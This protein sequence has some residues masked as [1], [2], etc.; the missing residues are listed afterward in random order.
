MG[1]EPDVDYDKDEPFVFAKSPRAS[2]IASGEKVMIPPG[3]HQIDWEVELA[4]V[5]GKK[6]TRVSGESALDFVFGYTLLLD[7]S[8]RGPKNRKDPRFNVDWFS[9]KSRDGFAPVG[10][11][12]VPAEF[13]A[14]PNDLDLR[15]SVNGELMQDSNTSYMVH[16]VQSLIAYITSIQT[17]EPGDMIATGTP[18]GVGAGRQPPV[19]LKPGDVITAEIEKICEIR[20]PIG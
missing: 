4:V 14:D 2:M 17:L 18:A 11:L 9:S 7:I 20:T 12:I 19:F 6:A 8:D 16:N 5:M 15:L 1:H 3:R 13:V 10:P